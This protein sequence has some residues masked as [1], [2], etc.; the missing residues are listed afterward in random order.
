MLTDDVPR[1][2][3]RGRGAPARV[4]DDSRAHVELPPGRASRYATRECSVS[5]AASSSR[6]ARVGRI[7]SAIRLIQVVSRLTRETLPDERHRTPLIVVGPRCRSFVVAVVVVVLPRD[8]VEP[9]WTSRRRGWGL[10]LGVAARNDPAGDTLPRRACA[11]T[12]LRSPRIKRG[13]VTR[14]PLLFSSLRLSSISPRLSRRAAPRPLG[15]D[16]CEIG[17]ALEHTH[18]YARRRVRLVVDPAAVSD[19]FAKIMM[20]S[21]LTDRRTLFVLDAGY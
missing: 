13:P 21:L 4:P 1:P 20:L 16:R 17:G 8:D 2:L 18:M 5:G 19:V 9:A 7:R 14:R 10:P 15:D 3:S 6:D 11:M 12:L